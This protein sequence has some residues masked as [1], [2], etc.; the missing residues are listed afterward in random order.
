MLFPTSKIAG[1]LERVFFVR[2]GIVDDLITVGGASGRTAVFRRHDGGEVWRG[3]ESL[4]MS[5]RTPMQSHCRTRRAA[6]PHGHH[7]A[8]ELDGRIDY[9][10]I[11]AAFSTKIRKKW[12]RRRPYAIL[13]ACH[14]GSEASSVK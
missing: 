3:N 8:T 1:E 13:R 5:E 11:V 9:T 7:C 6:Q 4:H 12:M 14:R 10:W 2:T